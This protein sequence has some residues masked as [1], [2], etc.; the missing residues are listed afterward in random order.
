MPFIEIKM[1]KGRTNQQKKELIKKVTDV[2]AETTGCTHNDV[3]VVINE[4]DKE[5]WGLS[6]E[7]ASEKYPD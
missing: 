2:T 5:N 6:G 7:Q 3:Q 4:Y 1:F